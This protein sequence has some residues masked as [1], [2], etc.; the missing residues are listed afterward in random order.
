MKTD[1]ELPPGI[2]YALSVMGQNNHRIEVSSFDEESGYCDI[3]VY[4]DERQENPIYRTVYVRGGVP[5]Y[6]E[7]RNGQR[8]AEFRIRNGES[9]AVEPVKRRVHSKESLRR[10]D[11]VR[12]IHEQHDEHIVPSEA[13]QSLFVQRIEL[14]EDERKWGDKFIK[15]PNDYNRVM[16]GATRQALNNIEA[17]IVAAS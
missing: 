15:T 14:I 4:R 11:T 12:R 9:V 6:H 16:L 13:V 10:R 7:V 5:Y 1:I 8:M 17:Q 3:L 2:R